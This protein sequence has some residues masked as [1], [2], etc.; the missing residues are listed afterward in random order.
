MEGQS[1]LFFVGL[2]IVGIGALLVAIFGIL[3]IIRAF[4]TSVGWGFA[5]LFIPA[6]GPLFFVVKHWDV[7]KGPFLK[8][9]AASVMAGVGMA[10]ISLT[11]NVQEVP[12][13]TPPGNGGTAPVEAPTAP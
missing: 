10:V 4:Q 12:A 13:E 1:P 3:L 11:G 5:Y 2:G 8:A 6:F 7:A 9:L